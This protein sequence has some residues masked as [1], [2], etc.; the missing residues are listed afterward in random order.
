MYIYTY[1]HTR[2]SVIPFS[3]SKMSPAHVRVFGTSLS[4]MY[5]PTQTILSLWKHLNKI[6]LFVCF[7][8]GMGFQDLQQTN[9]KYFK[10]IW[11][12]FHW[13]TKADKSSMQDY[14]VW[15]QIY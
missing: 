3:T 1:T 12:D 13:S 14:A 5:F 9:K 2:F 7:Y 8:L 11:V 10:V 6:Y 15:P 4:L